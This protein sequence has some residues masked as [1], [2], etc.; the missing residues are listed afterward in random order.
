MS[1]PR[2]RTV[3][4]AA[5]AVLA[6]GVLA[7]C[8]GSGG[9]GGGE[10]P[11]DD[12]AITV[13]MVDN[14]QMLRL[15]KLTAKHFTGRTGIEVDFTTLPENEV[16]GLISQDFAN[17]TGRYDV[18]TISN[19]EA[20]NYA[21]KGW[22]RPLDSY[23]SKDESFDQSDILLPMQL[24][25]SGANGKVYAEPFYGESSMLMYRKDVF[26]RLGLE[27]P[28][29]PSWRQ[30]SRLAQR[31]DGA[32]AGMRGICLR[33]L[34]GWSEMI[35]P[36]TT[37]VNT[38]GGTWFD[39][40]WNAR[41]TSPGFTQAAE[42]YVGLVREHGESRAAQ[43]GYA[44]CLSTMRGGKSAM[45]YDATAGAGS[46]EA[47]TSPVK[48]KIGYVPAPVEKTESAGWLHTWAWSM[49]KASQNT[50]SAWKF[51]SWAS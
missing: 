18:A 36:L 33:G 34:P 3:R 20:R 9:P 7:A 28:A 26:A 21:G 42:F 40:D 48:G 37:L 43:A 2:G 10:T 4:I 5:A 24:S 31:T 41:L 15:Q 30:V 32:E 19:Y 17:Q 45:W 50:R 23:I 35:A 51:I 47:D 44:E 6:A 49:Q 14:P 29:N 27:M 25:L 39:K 38:F 12:K 13:L 46:L 1:I 22:L 16:R 8:G 11:R